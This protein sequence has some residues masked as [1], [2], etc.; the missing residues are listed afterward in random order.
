[1]PDYVKEAAERHFLEGLDAA[2]GGLGSDSCPYQLI[3]ANVNA[4]T[5]VRTAPVNWMIGWQFGRFT[6]MQSLRKAR[7]SELKS[8]VQHLMQF[9]R[10]YTETSRVSKQGLIRSRLKSICA[11]RR[12]NEIV[13]NIRASREFK[14]LEDLH[15]EFYFPWRES[16]DPYEF[17]LVDRQLAVFGYDGNSEKTLR[18]LLSRY[19]DRHGVRAAWEE[20]VRSDPLQLPPLQD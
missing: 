2:R 12:S 1:M 14:L 16:E 6:M 8:A 3:D 20:Y 7:V 11:N 5:E 17:R 13:K 18:Q 4:S 9:Q 10:E 19:G 15:Y